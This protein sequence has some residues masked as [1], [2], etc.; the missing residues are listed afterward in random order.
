LLLQIWQ[1]LKM[2]APPLG[3]Y[4][5]LISEGYDKNVKAPSF[6]LLKMTPMLV[7]D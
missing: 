1:E 5:V 3:P 2:A 6:S 7:K 4:N